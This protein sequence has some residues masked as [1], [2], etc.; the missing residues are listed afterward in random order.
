MSVKPGSV[1]EDGTT[2]VVTGPAVRAPKFTHE[3]DSRAIPPRQKPAQVLPPLHESVEHEPDIMIA[4]PSVLAE[5]KAYYD[6][7]FNNSLASVMPGAGR[8]YSL[9]VTRASATS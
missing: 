7:I 1:S 6:Q 2:G 8:P 3:Q 9:A 5:K 4:E